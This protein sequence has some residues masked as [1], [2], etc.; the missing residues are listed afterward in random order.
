MF[1]QRAMDLHCLDNKHRA[2]RYAKK[3][4]RLCGG[5]GY[6]YS[7]TRSVRSLCQA[8]SHFTSFK[9]QKSF[10]LPAVGHDS[11]IDHQ[12]PMAGVFLGNG[13]H[14]FNM[15]S[16]APYTSF[17]PEYL[18]IALV[19]LLVCLAFPLFT[20]L[21]ELSFELAGLMKEAIADKARPISTSLLDGARRY[22]HSFVKNTLTI[23]PIPPRWV[24][25]STTPAKPVS[26][27]SSQN[28]ATA[29]ENEAGVVSMTYCCKSFVE[30]IKIIDVAIT[31]LHEKLERQESGIMDYIEASSKV[32]DHLRD[33]IVRIQQ[34]RALM[35]AQMDAIGMK[36][37]DVLWTMRQSNDGHE[38][39]DNRNNE[40][41]RVSAIPTDEEEM[42]TN[43][44]VAI[45]KFL[46]EVDLRKVEEVKAAD[47]NGALGIFGV[48]GSEPKER[49][50]PVESTTT[51]TE[52]KDQPEEKAFEKGKYQATVQ[53]EDEDEAEA[54][55][56][57]PLRMTRRL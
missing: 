9:S 14:G 45:S 23:R 42:P 50:E 20:I 11:V 52:V 7:I 53:D 12:V 55:D 32:I 26:T 33:D 16:T 15:T 3:S 47:H 51:I 5:C 40:A 46:Q 21:T 35:L 41:S 22:F 4:S 27:S 48:P 2:D 34:H 17:T 57:E 44:P 10:C 31:C 29:N 30:G 56:E 24:G 6:K 54:E 19:L 36:M 1:A 25:A 37:S 18:F 43:K 8:P 13:M 28:P 49:R 39:S 38:S